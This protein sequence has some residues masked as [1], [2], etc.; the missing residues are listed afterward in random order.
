[1]D[2][3]EPFFLCPVLR[4]MSLFKKQNSLLSR[5]KNNF[6]ARREIRLLI[7]KTFYWLI[8]MTLILVLDI[9]ETLNIYEMKVQFFNAPITS[10]AFDSLRVNKKGMQTI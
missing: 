7:L 9:Y 5:S 3:S 1:M 4:N 6:N 2:Y 8:F 10:L